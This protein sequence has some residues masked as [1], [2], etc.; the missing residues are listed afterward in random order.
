MMNKTIVMY[1]LAV[2]LLC[3][4]L[5]ACRSTPTPDVEATEKAALVAIQTAQPTDTPVPPT[6]TPVPPTDTPAPTDTLVPPTN[7]PTPTDTPDPTPTSVPPTDTPTPT[8]TPAP[9]TDTPTPAPPTSTPTPSISAEQQFEQGI[10]YFQNEQW[11]E[12]IAAFQTVIQLNPQVGEAYGWL[13]Y[14][15]VY[16][17]QAYEPAIA[18]LEQ[19][20]QLVPDADNRSEVLADIEQMRIIM[21]IPAGKAMFVFY[22]YSGETWLV[23]VG[24]YSLEVPPNPPDRTYTQATLVIEPGTYTWQAHSMDAGY[25]ITDSTGNIAFDF[26]LG[27]GEFYQT[28]CCN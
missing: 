3:L 24:S 20:L 4:T 14:S 22:N 13:G 12:A 1:S 5:S 2:L 9:P 15:Y 23:D 6:N 19:Y 28:S 25:Y 10:A 26:T 7:T 8:H 21:T 16:G 11:D 17:P 27:V 18:A